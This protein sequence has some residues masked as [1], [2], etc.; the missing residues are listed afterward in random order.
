MRF[1]V[2]D[3]NSFFHKRKVAFLARVQKFT[4]IY[5]SP[6]ELCVVFVDNPYMFVNGLF[7]FKLF[8]TQCAF[9]FPRYFS[10]WA[11]GEIS[12]WALHW[13]QVN[14]HVFSKKT[15]GYKF[16]FAIIAIMAKKVFCY[17]HAK[18][19]RLLPYMVSI[20][21]NLQWWLLFIFLITELTRKAIFLCIYL[22]L[23]FP[24][25]HFVHVSLVNFNGVVGQEFQ[26]TNFT[27]V[28]KIFECQVS[29]VEI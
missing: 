25:T 20:L 10:S 26:S 4:F 15:F 24:E 1:Q 16:Q 8:V 28:A 17:L 5:W 6:K 13:F 23:Q 22:L 12:S 11:F 19:F 21:V 29:Q 14:C 3:Q 18:I 27:W 2:S 9:S 7:C